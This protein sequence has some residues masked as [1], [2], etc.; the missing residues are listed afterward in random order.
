MRALLAL[1]ATE[2]RACEGRTSI[3]RCQPAQ[4]WQLS[5]SQD[6]KHT[7]K[8]FPPVTIKIFLLVGKLRVGP[9]QFREQENRVVTKSIC[10]ARRFRHHALRGIR[11]HR[12]HAPLLRNRRNANKFRTPLVTLLAFHFAQ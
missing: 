10:A 2:P 1:D 4:K 7:S 5:A 11:S 6:P 8:G 9:T 3:R 12:E